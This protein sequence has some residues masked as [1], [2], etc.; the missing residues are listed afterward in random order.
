MQTRVRASL[1]RTFVDHLDAAHV[2]ALDGTPPW[3]RLLQVFV[4]RFYLRIM[5]KPRTD[6]RGHEVRQLQP[7]VLCFLLRPQRLD[8]VPIQRQTGQHP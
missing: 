6:H 3:Y 5:G 2:V 1:W 4:V 8:E 7:D